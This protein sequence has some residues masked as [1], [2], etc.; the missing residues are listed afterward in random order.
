MTMEQL[1]EQLIKKA[2]LETEESHRQYVAALNGLAG[3]DII[4]V[5][6]DKIKICRKAGHLIFSI[7]K[8]K[9]LV[10]HFKISK[11]KMDS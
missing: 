1:L 8:I 2:T 7:H 10:S 6:L 4:Q 9:I 3:V 5:E 11:C